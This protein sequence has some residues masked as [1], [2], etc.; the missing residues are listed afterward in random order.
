MYGILQHQEKMKNPLE[1]HPTQKPLDLL[2]RIL[3]SSTCDGDL[4]LD[5]FSG[6]GTTGVACARSNRKLQ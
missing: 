6:S 2:E 5:P 1:G 4:V 3:A